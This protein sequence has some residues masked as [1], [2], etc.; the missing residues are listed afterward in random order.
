MDRV[1]EKVRGVRTLHWW[2]NLWTAG[3]LPWR[4]PRDHHSRDAYQLE[5]ERCYVTLEVAPCTECTAVRGL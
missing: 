4:S 5:A 2:G 1:K 3:G